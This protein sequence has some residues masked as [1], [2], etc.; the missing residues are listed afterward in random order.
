VTLLARL[1]RLFQLVVAGEAPKGNPVEL[2][3]VDGFASADTD[4]SDA[5]RPLLG[6]L[7]RAVA[8]MMAVLPGALAVQADVQ[9]RLEVAAIVRVADAKDEGVLLVVWFRPPKMTSVERALFLYIE[10]SKVDRA[11]PA[12]ADMDRLTGGSGQRKRDREDD[13]KACGGQSEYQH[14]PRA[15]VK[16]QP[17]R[18]VPHRPTA[19][20]VVGLTPQSQAG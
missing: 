5:L 16:T 19:R 8:V 18:P 14:P 11:L 2:A 13:K 20:T 7:D 15:R 9:L 6:Q 4:M 17:Q 12:P 3:I 1:V 10:L